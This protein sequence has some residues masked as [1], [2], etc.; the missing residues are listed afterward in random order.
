MCPASDLGDGLEP[1]DHIYSWYRTRAAVLLHL[2]GTASAGGVPG[3]VRLG[4]YQEGYTAPSQPEARFEAYLM[5][6][7]LRLVHT[8][9]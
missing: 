1:H 2:P 4:G 3:V 6:Y 7:Y 8:A 9:V 5:N